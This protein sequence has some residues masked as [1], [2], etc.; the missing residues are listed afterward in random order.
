MRHEDYFL[1]S[2]SLQSLMR[3]LLRLPKRAGGGGKTLVLQL[4]FRSFM[5]FRPQRGKLT[6]VTTTKESLNSH[7]STS[8]EPNHLIFISE[9]SP[10]PAYS[11]DDMTAAVAFAKK[12]PEI[13]K[14]KIAVKYGVN[15]TTLKRR[16]LGTQ[17][18]AVE[19]HRFQQL[20]TK[21]EEDAIRN[22][23]MTMSDAGFPV[24]HDILLNM[25]QSILNKRG[26]Q[27]QIGGLWVTRF[28]SRNPEVKSAYVEYMGNDRQKAG[29]DE[30]AQKRFY[31]LLYKTIRRIASQQKFFGI[32]MKR[33]L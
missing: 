1:E 32:V 2:S 22:W 7:N 5:G 29:A 3:I 17:K 6:S 13:L 27:H 10:M 28:L 33:G 8:T 4:G 15:M 14:S 12:H 16:C 24:T 25:A 19:G 26:I 31:N 20:F 23:C 9:A 30:E 18:T 11:P 21:G